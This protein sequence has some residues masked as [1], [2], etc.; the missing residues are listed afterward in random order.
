MPAGGRGFVHPGEFYLMTAG[1][2]ISHTET[3]TEKTTILHG[4]Q[5]WIALP[6]ATRSTAERDLAYF[7]PPATELDGGQ[8]K[9]F[10][11]ELMGA[12]S[13]VHSHTPMVGAEITIDPHSEIVLD[14]N[15]EFE[16]GV[17]ADSGTIVVADT[18]LEKTQ[19]GYT[20]IGEKTL[21]IRNDSDEIGRVLF[22]G[23]EPLREKILMWWNFLGRDHDEI[24]RYRDIWQASQGE[25][26]DGQFG[27]VDG[28]IGHGGVGED[29]LGRNA[30]GM[31]W[32]PAPNLPNVRMR[33]RTLTE[34][35]A[36]PNTKI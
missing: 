5:L 30:D 16:H 18:E 19:I 25:D 20:G 14:L 22:I 3:T 33:P 28:Y 21:R 12:S 31:T 17:I 8:L 2:G 10:M 15:P 6:D 32:L 36:R 26:V 1:N 11:G 34:P 27:F 9:V 35:V 29:G 13:P 7:K 4:V 23:G 24:V